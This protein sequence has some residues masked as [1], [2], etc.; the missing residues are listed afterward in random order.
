[1]SGS[2]VWSCAFLL[3]LATASLAPQA[4]AFP[5]V[6]LSKDGVKRSIQATHIVMM[7]RANTSVVT[8]MP[9]YIGPSGT[10]AVVMPVPSDVT[11]DRIRVVK[12][13]YLARIE[14]MTAPRFHEFYEQDPCD[15]G[16][17]QQEWE[18]DL[19]VHSTGFLGGN[20]E[21]GGGK[22]VPREFSLNLDTK[23][24]ESESEYRFV[25]IGTPPAEEEEKKADGK[26]KA[27]AKG[28]DTKD[29]ADAGDDGEGERPPPETFPDLASFAA[30]KGYQVP[31]P[32][33][34]ALTKYVERGMVLVV[35]EVDM[36]KVELVSGERGQLA[37][38]RYWST[39]PITTL[40]T[41]LGMLS[42]NGKQDD[43]FYVL[44][45]DRRWEPKNYGY[46]YPPTN[47]DTLQVI[48][49]NG[50]DR[51]VKERVS[52]VYN[53]IFDL[54]TDQN[55]G[56]F[57]YE[58]AW[59][60][61]GCGQPCPNE[62]LLINELL[63]LGGDVLEEQTV[64]EAERKPEPPAE[65][66]EEKKSF[67]AELKEMKP[68]ERVEAKKVR[69]ADRYELARRKALLERHNYVVS[70][71]HSRFD[72]TAMKKDV[73]VGP[74]ADQIHGGTDIPKGQAHELPLE[75]TKVKT[76]GETSKYQVRFNHFF[77]WDGMMQCEQPERWRWGKRW[78]HK[79]VWNKIWMGVDLAYKR[80]NE[81]DPRT[82]VKS[83]I[84]ALGLGNA[85]PAPSASAAASASA[86]ASGAPQKRACGCRTAGA[87]STSAPLAFAAAALLGLA[88]LRRRRR[89][90]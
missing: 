11:F 85:T 29:D 65:T 30:A 16:P 39:Q 53:A 35:A 78:R 31:G 80:R 8:V 79:R 84:P 58:Y 36:S 81:I 49:V 88:A 62:P 13:E 40:P 60:S 72:A 23:F 54:V 21:F 90:V 26:A 73:E 2:R 70:R 59:H 77:P 61:K 24:K 14:E 10:F 18:R 5:G 43:F 56:K 17:I 15:P 45:P 51:Y 69:K 75:V 4:A 38:I 22:Q 3:S 20:Q 9:D 71:F 19:R 32:I 86:S 87:G 52:E 76:P 25:W 42:A 64:P 82:V 6:Y 89:G 46:V 47:I 55:P 44:H 7:H 28:K 12:R 66:D 41:T 63:T 33:A 74:A 48:K 57:V 1:M 34:A 67:E 37:G 83:Q 50:K 27:K 68:A